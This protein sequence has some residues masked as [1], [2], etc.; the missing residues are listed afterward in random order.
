MKRIAL[1][2]AL[3]A[4]SLPALADT[5][6][7]AKV[8]TLGAGVDFAMPLTETIDIRLGL[9]A[10]NKSFSRSSASANGLS[11][12]Y[13][14]KINLNSWEAL[15]DWH[16]WSGSFRL[17]GG[18]IYNG[19][20]VSMTAVPQAG[21]INV[22]GR[23]IIIPPTGGTVNAEVSF[24][25]AAPYLGIGYGS[26]AKDTGLSLA[27]DLGIMFQGRP[28]ANVTSNIAGVTAADTTQ[29]N[30]DLNNAM[31]SFRYYPVVSVGL[32]YTF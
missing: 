22:G 13:A 7:A 27:A 8:S 32:G 17:T 18:L 25:K 5:T 23:T 16:P 1:T 30:S 15:I 21:T 12:N 6:A 24:Q 10:F 31:K 2:A 3:L 26:V 20:K 29:A 9:N 19:N 4:C 11:T 14:G 28:M